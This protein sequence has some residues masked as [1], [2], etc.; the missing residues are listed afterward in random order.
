M[1]ISI[2]DMYNWSGGGWGMGGQKFNSDAI[3]STELIKFDQLDY[4]S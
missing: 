4:N 2:V 1:N 3:N